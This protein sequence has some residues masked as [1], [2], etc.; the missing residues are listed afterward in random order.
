MLSIHAHAPNDIL[1]RYKDYVCVGSTWKNYKALTKG[2][3]W[4]NLVDPETTCLKV[5][6]DPWVSFFG[7]NTG[8]CRM[9]KGHD[10]ECADMVRVCDGC[11]TVYR[12]DDEEIYWSS[13][14]DVQICSRCPRY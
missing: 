7:Y 11:D 4:R 8:L 3:A 5:A 6:N 12:E 13:N 1:E 14:E 10:G 9:P 2:Q